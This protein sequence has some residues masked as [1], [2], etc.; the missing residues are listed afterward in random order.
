MFWKRT[1]GHGAFY[2]LLGGTIAAF[3][4]HMLSLTNGDTPG[5][6]KGGNLAPKLIFPSDMGKNFYMALT[7]WTVCF[8]LTI[9]VS[10]LTRQAKTDEDLTG[11]VYSLT[12]RKKTEGEPWYMQPVTLGVIILAVTVALNLIF[13]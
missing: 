13:L 4:F 10:L 9:I 1:T 11:L 6:V 7:A 3:L 2:G 8:V 5:W 12:P